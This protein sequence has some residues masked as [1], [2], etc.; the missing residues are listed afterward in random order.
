MLSSQALAILSYFPAPTA[1]G[2]YNNYTTSGT[3]VIIGNQWN[4]RWDYYGNQKNSFFGRYSYAGFTQVAPGVYGLL[5]GGPDL[6]NAN[7]AGNSSALNQSGAAGWTYTASSTLIN[8]FR[9][10]YMRYHVT[11]VPNA[12]G[13][14]PA[15]NAGIPGLKTS[16]E[17]SRMPELH[18]SSFERRRLWTGRQLYV[19]L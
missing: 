19:P 7:Y 17:T 11:D 15:L 18:I 4:T 6:N 1:A 3:D 12:F 5:A 8:E 13:S 14:T 2:P 10:G 16:A 9:F